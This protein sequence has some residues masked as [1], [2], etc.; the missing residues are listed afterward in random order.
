MDNSD[1][2]YVI[3][4]ATHGLGRAC[5]I[6]LVKVSLGYIVL[7]CRNRQ[8]AAK[9]ASKVCGDFSVDRGRLI[10][11]EESLDLSEEASVKRYASSLSRWLKSKSKSITTLINNAGLGQVPF[12]TNSK[13][14]EMIF[15]TN[16]LGHFLLTILLLPVIRDRVVFVSSGTHDPDVRTPLPDPS[17]GYPQTESEYVDQALYGRVPV[18]GVMKA[19]EMR[20]TRSKLFL[21]FFEYELA[22]RLNGSYPQYV[23]DDVKEAVGK[24]PDG[25]SCKLAKAKSISVVAMDPGLIL[26]TNANTHIFGPVIAL[27]LW[28]L[29]PLL[30]MIPYL[31]RHMRTLKESAHHLTNLA[32]FPQVGGTAGYF[33][34]GIAVPSSKFSLSLEGL[35]KHAT[36]LWDLSMKWS[37][38]TDADLQS[39]GL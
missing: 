28:L 10:V 38:M 8:E 6:E 18:A 24:L 14:Y 27:I 26:E 21:M 4:G 37:N 23:A 20:Y 30:R 33:V 2:V 16:Y 11:L 12:S 31:R 35:T 15:A 17:I 13:G 32:I 19:R 25:S 1:S 5:L 9:L 3:T 39:A 29:I 22:R 34:D 36:T 7:A